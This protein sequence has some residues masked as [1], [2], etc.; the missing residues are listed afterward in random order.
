MLEYLRSS[1]PVK[2]LGEVFY[3]L[4]GM[5]C[6]PR[7]KGTD[8]DVRTITRR[9]AQTVIERLDMKKTNRI[10]ASP[11]MASPSKEADASPNHAEIS[12]MRNTTYRKAL[13]VLM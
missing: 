4:A 3:H 9:Y 13:E 1:F 7:P 5:P 6:Y 11:G 12:D 2:D 8:G 10:P